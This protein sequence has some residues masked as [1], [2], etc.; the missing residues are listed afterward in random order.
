MSVKT[1]ELSIL[2]AVAQQCA[3]TRRPIS[4]LIVMAAC[5]ART[6]IEQDKVLVHLASLKRQGYVTQSGERWEVTPE[7]HQAAR[8]AMTQAA[9][10][11]RAPEP[12]PEKPPVRPKSRDT[13]RPRQ[14]T[15]PRPVTRPESAP[16]NHLRGA[17]KKVEGDGTGEALPPI[18]Y[19]G[20][21][22]RLALPIPHDLLHRCAAM[23]MTLMADARQRYEA[24]RCPEALSE[25]NWLAETGRLL[26]KA[27]GEV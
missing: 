13:L 1:K 8:Q 5:N 14:L 10:P 19:P 4:S 9:M 17:T 22:E 3:E 2:A 16:S 24:S 25:I 23:N 26:L 18:E 11:S 15:A 27:G 20:T 7:G 12:I 21:I 6:G